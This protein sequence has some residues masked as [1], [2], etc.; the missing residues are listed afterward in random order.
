MEGG[1]RCSIVLCTVCMR[2]ERESRIPT[3]ALPDRYSRYMINGF[4][5][6]YCDSFP[7]NHLSSF[8]PINDDVWKVPLI[9][10]NHTQRYLPQAETAVS[11]LL[12]NHQTTK[13]RDRTPHNT[14]CETH[15][16]LT[17]ANESQ[18]EHV[19][20]TGLVRSRAPHNVPLFV[21]VLLRF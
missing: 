15:R 2:Q 16:R 20:S 19:L 1:G 8:L 14:T 11:H 9:N 17:T 13:T 7:L 3:T 10:T 12:P 18:V 5:A 4:I 21:Y 6:C